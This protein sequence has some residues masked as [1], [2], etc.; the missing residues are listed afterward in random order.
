MRFSYFQSFLLHYS[1]TFNQLPLW[2]RV[3]TNSKLRFEEPVVVCF[4]AQFKQ[5][6]AETE[7]IREQ[8]V[9]ALRLYPVTP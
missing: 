3:V 2:R 7:P 1:G 9:S 6:A 8:P 4:Q 5:L